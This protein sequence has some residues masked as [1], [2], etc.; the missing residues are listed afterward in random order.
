M[1]ISGKVPGSGYDAKGGFVTFNPGQQHQRPGLALFN[2]TVY[3][4]FGSHADEDPDHCL[5]MAYD[6]AT[7]AQKSVY[8][9]SP[10]GSDAALWMTG[11]APAI[12]TGV[13]PSE[14]STEGA[15]GFLPKSKSG[16]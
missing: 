3:V 14:R 10:N 12:G 7:L 9:V 16:L 13:T 6:A 2:G 8:C 5:L 4:A 15:S 1:K 11:C